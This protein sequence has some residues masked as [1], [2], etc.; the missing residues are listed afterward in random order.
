MRIGNIVCAM[1]L[2]TAFVAASAL[3][4]QGSAVAKTAAKSKSFKVSSLDGRAVV[5]KDNRLLGIIYQTQQEPDGMSQVYLF[6]TSNVGLKGKVVTLPA[7][8]FFG[9][10]GEPAYMVLKAPNLS[11]SKLRKMSADKGVF[12]PA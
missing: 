2:G 5:G 6:T 7:S 10:Q 9:Q 4:A 1:F 8:M 3:L 11:P 12:W